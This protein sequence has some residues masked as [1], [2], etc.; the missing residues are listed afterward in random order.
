MTAFERSI[1]KTPI[2]KV[3]WDQLSEHVWSK[4]LSISFIRE[5]ADFL[6]WDKISQYKHTIN[7]YR[8]FANKI[9]WWRVTGTGIN[10]K[11]VREF[12]DKW[13]DGF[14]WEQI[15]ENSKLSKKFIER[16]AELVNWDK[17]FYQDHLGKKFMID[18]LDRFS[19]D[20]DIEII[21]QSW[22]INRYG[23]ECRDDYF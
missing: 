22:G 2:E 5:Y 8:E 16:N 17:V 3:N 20:I 10:E 23:I 13:E 4:E 18:N 14:D 15:C 11:K 12:L 7:F 9:R 19:D 21:V 1:R 6:N